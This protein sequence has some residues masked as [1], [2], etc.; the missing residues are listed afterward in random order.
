YMYNPQF[1]LPGADELILAEPPTDADAKS[2]RT[3]A[4]K[5]LPP[6][7]A[8][9]Y[10]LPLMTPEKERWAFRKYNYLKFRADHLRKELD[11]NRVKVA[12]VRRI[13]RLL[14]QAQVVKNQITRANLRLVVSIAR[15]HLHGSQTLFELVSDGNI[16]L[17]RAVEKFDYFRG[18]KFST[19]ASWAIIRNYARSVPKERYRMGR[20][21]TGAEE[22][23]DIVG[24]LDGYD[25]HACSLSELRDS[26]EVVLAQLS[27]RERS[28]VVGHFGINSSG[29]TRTLDQISRQMGLSKERI[30]QIEQGAMEK[31][32][33][34]LKPISSDL[35]R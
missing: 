20:F 24:G 22:V 33:S 7:L 29:R 15:K 30:R 35:M 21:V 9:L 27:A 13:E 4:P 2:K 16:S 18:F 19:Y 12:L 25:P 5:G 8:S 23:M 31:L 17:M 34:M 14:A 6:Y 26:L 1:D 11:T 28:I 3:R 10:E 32:R